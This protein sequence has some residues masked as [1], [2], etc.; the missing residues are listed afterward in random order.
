MASP[1]DVELW[2]PFDGASKLAL[3]IPPAKC[4][5]FAVNP[6]KWLRFLGHAIY[7]Q[8][9]YLSTSKDGP[10]IDNYAANIEAR[11]YYFISQGKSRMPHSTSPAYV[12]AL[13]DRLTSPR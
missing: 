10:E 8:G 7:R 11:P 3:S 12:V 2:L 1:G 13:F 6:L 5:G 9:G 4:R